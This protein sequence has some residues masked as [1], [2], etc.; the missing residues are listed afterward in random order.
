MAAP[1]SGR[2]L[3]TTEKVSAVLRLLKGESLAN[4][5]RELGV[6]VN[7]LERWQNDFVSAGSAALAKR[8]GSDRN[9]W[10]SQHAPAILQWIA[11]LI[12]LAVVIAFLQRFLQ[13]GGAE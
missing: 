8:N 4:L 9:G 3:T 10:F 7:R 13:R 1:A 2:R 12:V 11:F 5:S 6:G